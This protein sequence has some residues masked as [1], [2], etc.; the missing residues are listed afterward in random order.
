MSAVDTSTVT[1][2]ESTTSDRLTHIVQDRDQVR[3]ALLEGLPVR[4]LCGRIW[5]PKRWKP[6]DGLRCRVC[7]DLA[8][9][10]Y[11]VGP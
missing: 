10:V 8:R 5:V 9:N 6:A 2:R 1:S 4:A 3:R 7:D 11:P